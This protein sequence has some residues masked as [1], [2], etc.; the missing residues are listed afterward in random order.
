MESMYYDPRAP[1]SFGGVDK[2]RRYAAP[3]KQRKQVVEYLARQD[4]YTLHKPSRKRFARRRTYSKGIGDL[5][6]IDLTDLTNLSTYNDGYRYLLNCIDVFTKRAWCVPLKTKTGREVSNAFERILD[7]RSCNMVQSDKG[8]EFVNS[9]FQSMLQRRGI[10]FYTSENEDIKAAI[11]ERF[12]RTLKEKMYRYFTAKHTR[13]YADV[14]QDIV[15]AYNHTCHRSIGMAPADVTIDNE[16]VVRSRLYPVQ[17]KLLDWKFKVGDKVRITMQRRPFQKGYIGNWSEEIFVVGTRM[18]TAPVTYKLK[19]L[20]G[21]DIKGTFYSDELQIVSKPDDALFDIE[22]IVKTRKRA[23]K[24]EYLV[25]W[26]GY[27]TKFNSWVEA[28]TRR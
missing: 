20:A 23:G 8:T 2:L 19:D 25:K 14:L 9:T 26:R 16:D 17:T 15:H 22:Y 3:H 4:A 21:D 27:P 6:Q 24:V 12:N 18:P 7:D 28:L 13:R 1:G 5:Y 11:V 10:K